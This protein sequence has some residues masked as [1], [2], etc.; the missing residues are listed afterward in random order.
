[1]F[2]IYNQSNLSKE[3]Y[4]NDIVGLIQSG[5]GLKAKNQ[6]FLEKKKFCLNVTA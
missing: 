5:E 1:M 3:D 2:N 6:S 4:L